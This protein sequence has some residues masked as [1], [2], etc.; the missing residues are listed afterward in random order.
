MMTLCDLGADVIKV[1]RPPWG[2]MGRTNRPLRDG[3]FWAVLVHAED[4]TVQCVIADTDEFPGR[5]GERLRGTYLIQG[6]RLTP[7]RP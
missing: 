5:L 3:D 1:E 4:P 7:A 2:D 6:A